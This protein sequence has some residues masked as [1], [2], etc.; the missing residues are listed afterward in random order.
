MNTA[1]RRAALS[2]AL[3]ITA[4]AAGLAG[5]SPASAVATLTELQCSFEDTIEQSYG[6]TLTPSV[7]DFE[8]TGDGAITC[9]GFVDGVEVLGTGPFKQTG[10]TENT[11]CGAGTGYADY[12]ASIPRKDGHGSVK[13][14]GHV[15]WVRVGLVLEAHTTSGPR[16][17][18]PMYAQPLNGDCHN[19]PV[20]LVR[21]RAPALVTT[22]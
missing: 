19:E 13:I 22:P 21:L 15:E 7:S 4:A 3:T 17:A 12:R 14:A 5:G 18:G 1:L 6:L 9:T 8:S 16:V 11:W 20:T 2:A 10:H